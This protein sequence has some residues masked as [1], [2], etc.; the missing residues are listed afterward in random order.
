MR[1]FSEGRGRE[2]GSSAKGLTD[3]TTANERLAGRKNGEVPE[4][5]GKSLDSLT[6]LEK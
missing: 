4:K 5:P 6:L 1:E 2:I 3:R